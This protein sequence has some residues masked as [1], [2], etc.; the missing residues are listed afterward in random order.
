MLA[1]DKRVCSASGSAMR[2]HAGLW[3]GTMRG[4]SEELRIGVRWYSKTLEPS[5]M[6][7][8]CTGDASTA[9]A[10]SADRNAGHRRACTEIMHPGGECRS[11]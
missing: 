3:L 10:F 9:L 11:A 2:T 7:M 6:K 5:G 8:P 1:L 4:K